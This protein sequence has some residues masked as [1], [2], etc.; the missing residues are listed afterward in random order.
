MYTYTGVYH[1]EQNAAPEQAAVTFA[2]NKLEIGLK[3]EHGN[4]RNV[5]WF[6]EKISVENI[7]GDHCWLSYDGFPKQTLE[8]ISMDFAVEVEKRRAK[9]GK[10]ATANKTISALVIMGAIVLALGVALYFWIVPWLAGRAAM[11]VPVSYEE[12]LGDKAYQSLIGQY[13]VLPEKTKLANDFFKELKIPSAYKIR[14]TVVKQDQLNAFAIPGGNIIV[15]DKLIKQMKGPGELA[16][17][18]SHEFSHVELRHTTK[19]MFRSM[20]SYVMLSL[21][22]G[23]LTGVGAV[24][25]ENAHSLKTLQYSRSLEREADLNGLKLLDARHIGGDGFVGL[26]KT[27]KNESGVAPSEWMSSHPDLDNRVKYV[28]S[29]EH[30]QA[31]SVTDSTLIRIFNQLQAD[32][33]NSSW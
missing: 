29:D 12:S 20:G 11:S 32:G 4:P 18:L 23:D 17:L 3:D 28:E 1:Y 31:G 24:V 9:F 7:T 6:W 19:T 5:F 26:F 22:F 27:L 14:I 8:V 30:Y 2:N 21:V 16:A 25:V 15:Y 10:P 13:T 33:N